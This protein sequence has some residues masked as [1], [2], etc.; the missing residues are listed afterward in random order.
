MSD[1]QGPDYWAD[2]QYVANEA[3]SILEGLKEYLMISEQEGG[4]SLHGMAT[5]QASL[6][7]LREILLDR[8]G[9]TK[10]PLLD[11]DVE[12]FMEFVINEANQ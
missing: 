2:Q 8:Y 12:D 6:S 10:K 4:L 7:L 1:E 5:I 11:M 3:A 9:L